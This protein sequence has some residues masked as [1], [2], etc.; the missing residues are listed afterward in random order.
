MSM[1]A[2]VEG[3]II[4]HHLWAENLFSLKINAVI[5]P[6]KAGQYTS[7]GLEIAGELHAEP[8]SILSAPELHLQQPPQQQTLEFFLYGKLAGTLSTRL[9]GMSVGQQVMVR[10]Q[11]E[12][13]FTLDQVDSAREL[14][15][16]ATGT[17]V[18]PFLSM[19]Q[20]GEA[21]QRF[22][23]IVLVYAVRHRQDL[24]Y[25]ELITRLQARYPGQL[26]F[27]PVISRE[28]SAQALGGHIQDAIGN[29]TLEQFSGRKL[30]PE[31]SQI[32]LCGNPGMIQ[33]SNAVL[34]AR[35][36]TENRSQKPGAESGSEQKSESGS[37]KGQITFETY[38]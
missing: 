36:F 33:A 2:W 35:G 17:G 1:N 5:A 37:S 19:L 24:C 27:I 25:T 34:Q 38:W 21:W 7:L 22:A 20:T 13:N 10:Q 14:W 11:A 30:S 15:L 9:A 26:S 32:M 28:Q 3:R 29:G 23:H 6:F 18:A 31:H 16:L 8:Y 12:G 4:D